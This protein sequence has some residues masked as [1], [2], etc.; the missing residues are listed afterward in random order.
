MGYSRRSWFNVFL[1][2]WGEIFLLRW[3]MVMMNWSMFVMNWNYMMWNWNV[4]FNER[5]VWKGRKW[6]TLNFWRCWD[7]FCWNVFFW[8]VAAILVP[9]LLKIHQFT[10]KYSLSRCFMTNSW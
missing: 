6:E 1:S 2:R 5:K 7:E 10:R 4:I 9:E 8:T 3:G